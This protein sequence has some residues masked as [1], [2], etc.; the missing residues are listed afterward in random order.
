VPDH[1]EELFAELRTV[2]LPRVLPPGVDAARRTARRRRRT[3]RIVTTAAVVAAVAGT[4]AVAVPPLREGHWTSAAE[5]MTGRLDAAKRAVDT[6]L[7]TVARSAVSRPVTADSRS[8]FTDLEAGSYNLA[9]ACAGAGTVTVEARLARGAGDSAVLGGQVVA[10]DEAPQATYLTL[11]LPLDGSVVITAAGD[12]AAVDSAGYAL[13]LVPAAGP[14]NPPNQQEAPAPEST[15]NAARAAEILTASGRAGAAQVTTERVLTTTHFTGLGMKTAPGD[16]ELA[17]VCAGPG[18]LTL[19]VQTVATGSGGIADSG[20]TVLQRQVECR[21]TDP[22]V[23]ETDLL[24]LPEGSG[25]MLTAAPDPAAR[26]HAGWAY[27]LTPR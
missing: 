26:N 19:T 9:L 10:C 1:F 21:D 16:Y 8:T 4:L 24:T 2:T 23:G 7:P 20:P 5:R 27:H 15:W 14:G 11:R 25:F 13:D 17:L 3:T 6:Q 18:T 22:R 12:A